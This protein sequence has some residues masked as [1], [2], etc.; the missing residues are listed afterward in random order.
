MVLT[1]LELRKFVTAAHSLEIA[2][3]RLERN[4]TYMQPRSPPQN[5][6]LDRHGKV[7][8]TFWYVQ[9]MRDVQIGKDTWDV[10]VQNSIR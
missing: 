9:D 3:L 8:A 10:R 4:K 6:I 1:D 2:I 7:N 5:D